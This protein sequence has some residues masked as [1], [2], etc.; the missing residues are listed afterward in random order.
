MTLDHRTVFLVDDDAPVRK[1][2]SRLLKSA[3]YQVEAFDSAGE[4][5][6]WHRPGGFGCLILDIQMPGLNG[7]ELQEELAANDS[8]LA[9]IF[10]TGHGDI[11]T[12]VQ[13]MKAGAV[14]FLTKPVCG[15]ELLDAVERAL[16]ENHAARKRWREVKAIRQRVE[17]LTPRERE[18]LS[19]VVTG[20]LNKQI[21]VKLCTSEKTVKVHRGRVMRKLA[22]RSIADLIHM[23]ERAS[24]PAAAATPY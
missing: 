3:G 19:L 2:L 5:L 17:T 20:L 24:I 14:D 21:A 8:T 4:F 23:A 13:A 6:Q 22:A 1:A 18:V 9:I 11:P 15:Q 7:L 12:S 16:A 10:L